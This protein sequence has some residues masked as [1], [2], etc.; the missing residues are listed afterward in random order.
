MKLLLPAVALS[1]LTFAIAADGLAQGTTS[2]ANLANRTEAEMCIRAN[3]VPFPQG[4]RPRQS[5]TNSCDYPI[6]LAWCHSPVAGGDAECG[7]RGRFYQQIINLAP[8]AY[9]DSIYAMPPNSVIYFGV[10]PGENALRQTTNGAY[11]CK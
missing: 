1:L 11:I 4:S 6:S 3:V 2:T 8:Q 5:L 10:C 9:R 7:K